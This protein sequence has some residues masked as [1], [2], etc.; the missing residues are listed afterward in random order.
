VGDLN[1]LIVGNSAAGVAAALEIREHDAAGPITILSDERTWGYSRV[2]TTSLIEGSLAREDFFCWDEAFYLGNGLDL[3][4]GARVV[5]VAPKENQVELASGERLLYDRLLLA[6]GAR[7]VAPDIPGWDLAECL[8]LRTMADAE[9]ILESAQRGRKA[10]VAGAGLVGIK[11]ATAL[12]KAG[13]EVELVE[14]ADRILPQMLDRSSAAIAQRELM[15]HG[16]R[17]RTECQVTRIGGRA[18]QVGWVELT[19]GESL[20]CDLVIA[21]IGVKPNTEL[22]ADAGLAVDRGILVNDAMQTS[23]SAIYAAGDTA[24][25]YDAVWRERRV[26]AIWPCAVRQGRIA[27]A[28]MAGSPQRYEGSLRMNSLGIFGLSCMSM[29]AID[30]SRSGFQALVREDADG[31]AYRKIVLREN[32]IVGAVLVSR[33]SPDLGVLAS[34]FRRELDASNLSTHLL[35][36]RFGYAH[37]LMETLCQ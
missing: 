36:S 19:D 7:A 11:L 12:V 28:N 27:G 1:Y 16:I 24:Q 14:I 31:T 29:G 25:A 6:T 13:L 8:T 20:A 23:A 2:A 21:C 10:I 35:D 22:G 18:G 15:A 33:S 17:I 32:R 4:R 37:L 26:N 34:L 30:H 9:S 3:R 5:R